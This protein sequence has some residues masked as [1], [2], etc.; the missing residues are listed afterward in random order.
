M[1]IAV[2]TLKTAAK[3]LLYRTPWGR[4]FGH[5]YGYN[6]TPRQLCFLVSCIDRTKSLT[7]AIVEVGCF[8]GHTSIFLNTHMDVEAV[9]KP[10]YAIDTFS[11][12]VASHLE[13]ERIA[14]GKAPFVTAMRRAFSDNSKAL[15]DHQLTWN[16]IVRVR[17]IRADAA[18]FDYASIAPL[19]FALID[20]DLYL[21]VL[22]AL[23]RIVPLVQAGGLVVVDDCAPAQRYDGA[24]QAYTEFAATY[25]IATKV[26]HGKLGIVEL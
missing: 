7:G 11:G 18:T 3:A 6:F 4:R 13:H 1:G 15:F 25:G 19:S 17:S 22:R 8:R 12:F 20:V 14:R 21:P 23:E 26:V 16:A 9:D 5:R 10:Y 2:R 24:L